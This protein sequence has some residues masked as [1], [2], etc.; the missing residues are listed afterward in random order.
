MYTL[1]QALFDAKPAP[2]TTEEEF[3][4]DRE[5][6]DL[7]LAKRMALPVDQRRGVA[8][9]ETIEFLVK[10]KGGFRESRGVAWQHV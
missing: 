8:G 4:R 3:E 2:T 5:S 9:W 7:Q 1:A 10:W 6:M